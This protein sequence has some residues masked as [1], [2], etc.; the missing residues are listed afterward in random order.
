MQSDS[1]DD[2]D[3]DDELT[4]T[5]SG[6]EAA[7]ASAPAARAIDGVAQAEKNLGGAKG[8]F[9]ESVVFLLFHVFN[10][11][12]LHKIIFILFDLS[13]YKYFYSVTK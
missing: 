5:L 8:K 2:L 6:K 4:D 13:S 11:R 10:Y 1:F 9:V 7:A 12:R 3:K